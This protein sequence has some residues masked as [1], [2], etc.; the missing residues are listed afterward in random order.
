MLCRKYS[1]RVRK[2]SGTKLTWEQIPWYYNEEFDDLRL[3]NTPAERITSTI[4]IDAIITST[5]FESPLTISEA[6]LII[7]E[8][9][10]ALY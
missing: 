4:I 7:L 9:I 10:R 5:T 3:Y 1:V 2:G 8:E 6:S